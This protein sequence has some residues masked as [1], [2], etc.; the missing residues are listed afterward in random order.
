VLS[1]KVKKRIFDILLSCV[2]IF[3][4]LPV[5]AAGLLASAVVHRSTPLFVQTRTGKASQPFFCYK[6]KTMQDSLP[7]G[8][9]SDRA[10][11]SKLGNFLRKTSI[12]ELPQLFNI[13]LGEMSFIGPRPQ[14]HE[15]LPLITAQ[16]H[17]RYDVLPGLSGWSQVNGR[18]GI[19]WK[20]RFEHDLWYVNNASFRLDLYIVWLTILTVLS[21]RGVNCGTE[22]TMESLFE[23]RPPETLDESL[24]AVLANFQASGP[25]ATVSFSLH[26]PNYL[27]PTTVNP[28]HLFIVP[29]AIGETLN[30][31]NIYIDVWRRPHTKETAFPIGTVGPFEVSIKQDRVSIKQTR[32]TCVHNNLQKKHQIQSCDTRETGTF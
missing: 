7:S 14:L 15:Y 30:Y 24:P 8:D 29:S 17:R 12:D 13:L 20:Q 23:E 4:T 21:K 1:Y 16:E 31:N 3:V 32:Q 10:R 27:K 18:N 5:I 19:S 11:V 26:D 6:I 22:T 9:N 25:N 28:Y 2:M